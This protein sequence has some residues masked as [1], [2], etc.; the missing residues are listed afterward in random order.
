M[1]IL[2]SQKYIQNNHFSKCLM[3]K[4]HNQAR[5]LRP[6]ALTSKLM[7]TPRFLTVYNT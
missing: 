3:C 7:H 1:I 5:Q 6:L 2:Y 4:D